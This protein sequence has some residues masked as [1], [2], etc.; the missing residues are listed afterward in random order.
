ML[1]SITSVKFAKIDALAESDLKVS[2]I[3]AKPIDIPCSEN[4]VITILSV[5]AS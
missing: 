3:W 1:I 4:N 2:S 5:K